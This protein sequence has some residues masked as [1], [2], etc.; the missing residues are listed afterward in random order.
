MKKLLLI[1][2]T[3]TAAAC[4]NAAMMRVSGESRDPCQNDSDCYEEYMCV[5]NITGDSVLG[6]C[7]HYNH[8]DPWRHGRLEDI[9]KLKNKEKKEG[10]PEALNQDS[11]W[12]LS[13]VEE[14]TK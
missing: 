3:F 1:A 2:L 13:P 10:Q 7:I 14:K 12:W 5:K 8:Y 9:I 11:K 6:E 4:Y